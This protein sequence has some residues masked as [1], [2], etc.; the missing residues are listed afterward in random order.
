MGNTPRT[1]QH[2]SSVV[3]GYLIVHETFPGRQEVENEGICG[4]GSDMAWPEWQVVSRHSQSCR[5]GSGG[6]K[7]SNF[8][9]ASS[10]N[11]RDE[12]ASI[13]STE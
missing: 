3:L 1:A 12:L 6:S 13:A 4:D 9:F 5:L 8:S 10:H 11:L 7:N 2:G